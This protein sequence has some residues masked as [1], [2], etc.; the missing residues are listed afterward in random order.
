MKEYERM[1]GNIWCDNGELKKLENHYSKEDD[2]EN[3]NMG[4]NDNNLD[5]HRIEFDHEEVEG[6][7]KDIIKFSHNNKLLQGRNINNNG[8]QTSDIIS[9]SLENLPTISSSNYLNF[10]KQIKKRVTVYMQPQDRSCKVKSQLGKL[11]LLPDSIEELC[12]IAG[13]SLVC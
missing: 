2:D 11:I 5:E 7:E 13:R 10:S 8:G 6:G 12:K 3:Y 4:I 9:S 1:L